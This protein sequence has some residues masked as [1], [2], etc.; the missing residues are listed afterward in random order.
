MPITRQTDIQL[1]DRKTELS[2]YLFENDAQID[3][4]LGSTFNT[5]STKKITLKK[6]MM[7][8]RDAIRFA[9]EIVDAISVIWNVNIELEEY[10]NEEETSEEKT[11]EGE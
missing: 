3:I 8:C 6:Q 4:K 9:R 1:H 5:K 2:V 7:D 10:E 11:D